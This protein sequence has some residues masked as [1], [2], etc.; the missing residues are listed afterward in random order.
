[1]EAKSKTR[2]QEDIIG[3]KK[4]E[5]AMD[6]TVK[7]GLCV[8]LKEMQGSVDLYRRQLLKVVMVDKGQVT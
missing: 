4:E 1:M 2:R 8:L 3:L 6:E 5:K 7:L